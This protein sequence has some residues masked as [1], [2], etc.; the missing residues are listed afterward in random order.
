MAIYHVPVMVEKGLLD[1]KSGEA[2]LKDWEKHRNNPDAVFF[3][4]LVVDVAG[5]KE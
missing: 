4:P 5:R 1:K 2:I 3:S